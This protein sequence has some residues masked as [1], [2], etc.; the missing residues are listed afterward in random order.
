VLQSSRSEFES[1]Q[2][3]RDHSQRVTTQLYVPGVANAEIKQTTLSH[4]PS[5]KKNVRIVTQIILDIYNI[6]KVLDCNNRKL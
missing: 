2:G 3:T 1:T 4:S 5:M 6:M